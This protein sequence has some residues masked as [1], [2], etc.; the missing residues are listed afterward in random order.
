ML[1]NGPVHTQFAAMGSTQ[2]LKAQTQSKK[3]Q[4]YFNKK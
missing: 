1:E 4:S 2:I 3:K